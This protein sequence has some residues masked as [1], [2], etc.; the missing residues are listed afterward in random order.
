MPS[1]LNN[2][3][4][5]T[6]YL[7]VELLIHCARTHIDV[8]R[9]D[10]VKSLVKQDINWQYLLNIANKNKILPLLYWHLSQI[11]PEVI[12]TNELLFLRDQFNKSSKS[13]LF[14]SRE[15]L[16]I[17]NLF[18]SKNISVMPFKG[19]VMIYNLYKNLALR[20]FCD[21]DILIHKEDLFKIKELLM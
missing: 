14:L 6:K 10:R 15:L 9:I 17:F 16:K 11:V 21:L 5:S 12:S 19:P 18:E 13:N 3:I 4:P 7:E 20:E 2:F 8:E 1:E